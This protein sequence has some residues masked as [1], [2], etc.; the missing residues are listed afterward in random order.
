MTD[1]GPILRLRVGAYTVCV[2]EEERILLCRLS[3]GSTLSFDGHWTLPGGGVEHGEQPRDAALRELGEETGLTGELE[4]LLDV[5]SNRFS[6]MN[7]EGREVDF[8][9]IRVIYRARITG[10]S[11]REELG[12]TTDACRWFARNELAEAP[13]LDLAELA[14]R[15]VFGDLA[16]SET[17][18][19]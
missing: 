16:A 10:G 11:L 15:L 12:G 13:L 5:E 2:D 1:I 6:Y 14:V 8:H 3:P 4:G 18:E 9:G 17:A 7:R 19:V